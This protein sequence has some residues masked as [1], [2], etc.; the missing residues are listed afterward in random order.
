MRPKVLF[1]LCSI[2]MFL[3]M[4]S[5]SA[6]QNDIGKAQDFYLEGQRHMRDGNFTAANEAFMKAE[7]V[8]RT[9]SELP[10]AA[11]LEEIASG[12]DTGN[13]E[14]QPAVRSLDPDIYYNLGVG[15][16][17][18]GDFAQAEAAFLRVTELSPLDK[19]ACYNLGVLYEK[20]LD[21]PRAAIK[22]YTRY[23]NLSD[24]NDRDVGQVKGW[25]RDIQERAR[26]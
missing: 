22:Y 6:G 20:Y 3:M 9:V 1:Y 15:A 16:L 17:Q 2:A 25:I 12:P 26:R 18:K 5:A 11:A 21:K 14:A 10:Q 24:S 13:G 8:L 7:I 19:E 4:I 23:I